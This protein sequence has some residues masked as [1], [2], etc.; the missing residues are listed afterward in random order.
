M[1][2]F[3]NTSVLSKEVDVSKKFDSFT[4]LEL[5]AAANHTISQYEGYLLDQVGWRELSQTMTRLRKA[6]REAEALEKRLLDSDPQDY[7]K[8]I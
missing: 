6:A 3:L 8:Q 2:V 7:P 4:R 5:I 1:A